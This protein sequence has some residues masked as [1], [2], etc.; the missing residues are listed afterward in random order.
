VT[1][2][3]ASSHAR[4]AEVAAAWKGRA[5]FPD[6]GAVAASDAEVVHV[7]SPNVTHA[8][9][10]EALLKAGKH[11][12]CEKPLGISLPEAEHMYALATKSGLVATVPFVYRY[13]P[14]VREVRS[15]A[16]AGDFGRWNLLHGHYLQDWL[17]SDQASN[18]RVDGARGGPSR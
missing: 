5:A 17:L 3:L 2:V 12:I 1:G 10:V 8:P 13:H 6:I 16:A 14:I 7:C 18:W 9:F 15:R 4:S 11:V